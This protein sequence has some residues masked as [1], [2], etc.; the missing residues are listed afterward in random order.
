MAGN[1]LGDILENAQMG[2]E[3]AFLVN[4]DTSVVYYQGV[5]LQIQQQMIQISV[6]Y[7]KQKWLVLGVICF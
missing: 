3:N 4:Y 1:T 2:R 5:L 7:M 6:P